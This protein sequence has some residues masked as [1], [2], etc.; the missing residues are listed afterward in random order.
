MLE[1][2]R[3]LNANIPIFSVKDA[4]FLPYGRVLGGYEV[5]EIINECEKVKIPESGSAYKLSMSQ[6]EKL[7][8]SGKL[9]TDCFG[10]M[11]I[12]VGMCF[13]HNKLLDGLEYHRSSEVNIAVTNMVLL[14]GKVYEMEDLR[15]ASKNIK[16]FYVD[17]GKVIEVYGTSLHF[18]PCEVSSEG[19]SAVV[20]LHK[21][22]NDLLDEEAN[23]PLLF[24]KNKWL[25][26]HKKAGSLIERK[27][28]PGIYGE[29]YEIR[30]V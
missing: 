14:L 21:G 4:E 6:L 25:I 9:K 30:Y 18:C 5:S 26:C 29:N 3:K 17:K 24:K 2:I 15:Y 19:F 22:T 28:Y 10:Q 7:D 11:D 12:Q 8:I 13:G 23:D 16:G 27:V 1:M 20:V